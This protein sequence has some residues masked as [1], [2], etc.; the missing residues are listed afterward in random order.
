MLLDVETLRKLESAAELEDAVKVGKR[1][2]LAGGPGAGVGAL[3]K[4]VERIETQKHLSQHIAKWA[5]LQKH[6]GY[7]DRQIHKKFFLTFDKTISQALAEPKAEMLNTILQLQN[8][9]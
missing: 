4:Q 1:A 3:K 2:S 7:S 5:G 6:Y 8:P 9:Y